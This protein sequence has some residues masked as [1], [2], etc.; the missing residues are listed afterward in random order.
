MNAALPSFRFLSSAVC[1]LLVAGCNVIP[2]PQAD[3]TRYFALASPA[4]DNPAARPTLG[5]LRLGLKA[6]DVAPYL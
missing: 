3:S 2:P 1:L 5:T 6:V 4:L